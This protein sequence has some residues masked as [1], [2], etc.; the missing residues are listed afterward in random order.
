M[1]HGIAGVAAL[2]LGS[3]LMAQSPAG[4]T[5]AGLTM[6]DNQ[7]ADRLSQLMESTAVAV[8]GLV[9]ASGSV[10]QLATSALGA[11][12]EAPQDLAMQYRFAKLVGAYLALSD[13]FPHPQPFPQ[14]AEQQFSELRESAQKFQVRFETALEQLDRTAQ[15]RNA[16]PSNLAR[17][18][19]ANSKLPPPG[20]APRV[21]F[22]GDSITDA[23]R[24]NEYFTGRDFVNRGIS[25]QTT[26]QMVGRFLQDVVALKPKAVLILAGTNDIA[27]GIR[28]SAIE[29]NLTEMGE[30]AKASG[31][32]PVFASVL[33]VSD[34]HKD[35][36]ARFEATK[37]RPPALIRQMNSWMQEYCRREGF[38]Y[39]DY[40]AAMA[41]GNGFIPADMADDG[42]HPNSKGYRV[43]APLALDALN[44]TLAPVASPANEKTQKKKFGL[45]GK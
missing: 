26:L 23:W 41:D 42:L 6:T 35:V 22:F 31:I 12:H 17:Y 15:A 24:L 43:M 7:L 16:D 39:V 9:N 45:L 34:Y 1:R 3:G 18:A 19:D 10:R 13:T 20:V 30:L 40:F 21:V 11:M 29:D 44:R 33:P 27:Q 4:L 37:T 38:T 32:K 25:G 8:P 36:D 5:P 2:L 28:V 14:L